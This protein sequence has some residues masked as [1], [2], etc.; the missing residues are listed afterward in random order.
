MNRNSTNQGVTPWGG[1]KNA[2]PRSCRKFAWLDNSPPGR[3]LRPAFSLEE[4]MAEQDE[5]RTKQL[6]ELVQM[7]VTDIVA[8]ASEQG[9]S[10][11]ET[12]AALGLAVS[13]SAAA[14]E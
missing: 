1:T 4:T 5:A 7:E 13:A 11:K 3:P 12:L 2:D 8:A 10:A 9:F 14:L 6:E